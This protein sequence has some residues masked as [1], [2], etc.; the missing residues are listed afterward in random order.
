M[1]VNSPFYLLSVIASLHVDAFVRFFPFLINEPPTSHPFVAIVA[2]VVVVYSHMTCWLWIFPIM[3]ILTLVVMVLCGDRSEDGGQRGIT[4]STSHTSWRRSHQGQESTH[5][6]SRLGQEWPTHFSP[7]QPL[8]SWL[9]PNQWFLLPLQCTLC[10]F[11]SFSFPFPFLLPISKSRLFWTEQL[12]NGYVCFVSPVFLLLLLLL[13]WLILITDLLTYWFSQ[14]LTLE[15]CCAGFFVL[16]G[17][18]TC[19]W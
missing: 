11:L 8:Q 7:Y 1:T 5:P 10:L 16:W 2:V 9:S 4:T 6:A 3:V 19:W 17:W 15:T 14:F 13:N 12:V 18:E